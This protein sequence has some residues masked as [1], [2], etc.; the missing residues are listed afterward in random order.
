MKFSDNRSSVLTFSLAAALAV[1]AAGPWAMGAGKKEKSKNPVAEANNAFALDLLKALKNEKGNLF[2]SPASISTALA[3]T[4]AGAHGNTADEMEQT[5]RLDVSGDELHEAYEGFI[6][7]LA[8]NGKKGGNELNVAN[9]L[10]CEKSMGLLPAFSNLLKKQYRAEGKSLDFAAS[11][12]KSR[13]TI[14]AWVEKKTKDRIMDLIPSG[15]LNGDTRLVLTNA[16]YFKGAWARA[17][18]KK[19]THDAP[20]TVS[21]GKT[22]TVPMMSQKADFRYTQTGDVQVLE[23]DYKGGS[24]SMLVLLPVETDGLDDLEASLTPKRLDELAAGLSEQE[25]RVLLPRFTMTTFFDLSKALRSLG[26]VDAFDPGKA[27]FSG[28]TGSKNLFISNVL[29]KA[30]VDVAEEGTEA[31]AATAVIMQITCVKIEP[32]FRA[33][34]PFLFFIRDRAS[35]AVL[36]AGRVTD[37]SG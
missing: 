29:H 15:V 2:Y 12:E 23:L 14:N 19:K 34:H 36:F 5:L 27:D 8:K 32:L 17:F 9:A 4:Y 16:I 18:D 30:F 24:L 25:V 21:P 10:W 13:K 20:F 11:P 22:V 37:P 7:S 35:G 6:Q 1:M 28:I 33:D 26:M 31:A 3:M